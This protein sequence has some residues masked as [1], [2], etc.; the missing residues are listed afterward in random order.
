MEENLIRSIGSFIFKIK[1]KKSFLVISLTQVEHIISDDKLRAQSSVACYKCRQE[2]GVLV[3]ASEA[4]LTLT[5]LH[6]TIYCQG[7]SALTMD[8]VAS[9]RLT[10]FISMSSWPKLFSIFITSLS[11]SHLQSTS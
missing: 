9:R 6:I 8:D 4:G 10:T 2:A 1:K 5:S 7:A 11:V 3:K